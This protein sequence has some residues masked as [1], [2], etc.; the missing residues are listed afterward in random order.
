MESKTENKYI[1]DLNILNTHNEK[2]CEACNRKF[3]LG[4]SVVFACGAWTDDCARL[5]HESE[6]VFDENTRTWYER[7]YYRNLAPG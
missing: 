5:I 2:G 3:N 6:A 1:V 7:R 4:D